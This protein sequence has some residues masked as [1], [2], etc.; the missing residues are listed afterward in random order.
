M[1]TDTDPKRRHQNATTEAIQAAR[2]DWPKWRSRRLADVLAPQGNLALIET[3]W[4]AE[5]ENEEDPA[6]ITPKAALVGLPSTV[7][8]TKIAR[9][10]IVT[11]LPEDG[12]R[13]WD[14]RSQAILNFKTIRVFDFDPRWVI[15]AQ[16]APID[17]S[18]TVPFE[19]L[20]DSGGTRDLAVPGQITFSLD[21][22]D[23]S[24]SAFEDEGTLLLVFADRTNGNDDV[25]LR[26]YAAGRFL[27][28][29]R[30]AGDVEAGPV[31]L[32]FNQ[33]FIPPCGFSDEYNC[34][35]PPPQNRFPMPITAG[36][37]EI[38]SGIDIDGR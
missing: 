29:A 38:I 2:A 4:F 37:V 10:N 9:K 30:R 16:F 1:P 6:R 28:V 8:V 17:S 24:L 20:R 22:L 15:D 11:G 32:D 25:D 7:T 21:G 27:R 23:Y 31:V 5:G 18:R 26:T 13:L 36:E 35:L 19:H 12:I 34:P 33:A 3:R 14:S